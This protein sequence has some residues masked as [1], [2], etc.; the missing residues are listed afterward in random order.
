MVPIIGGLYGPVRR[1]CPP[2]APRPPV[3]RGAAAAMPRPAAEAIRPDDRE[4][5]AGPPRLASSQLGA[6]PEIPNFRQQRAESTSISTNHGIGMRTTLADTVVT[7]FAEAREENGAK[8]GQDHVEVLAYLTRMPCC[9]G[10]QDE[11][12][13]SA[14]GRGWGSWGQAGCGAACL[15]HFPCRSRSPACMLATGRRMGQR[16]RREEESRGERRRRKVSV[17]T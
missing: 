4:D 7:A 16:R 8:T 6:R 12:T 3:S 11:L 5:R 2:P 10:W 14:D 1:V 9:R 13:A 17:V 15:R